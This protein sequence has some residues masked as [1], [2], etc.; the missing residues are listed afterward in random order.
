MRRSASDARLVDR[1]LD[2]DAGAWEVLVDRYARLVRSIPLRYGMDPADAD[3]VA[4]QTFVALF[5]ALSSLRETDRLSSW[6]VTTAH[7]AS[8]RVGGR[9]ERS[10]AAARAAIDDVGSPDPDLAERWDLAQRVREALQRLGGRCERLLT[11]LFGA[12]G[13]PD[14]RT[15][16]D[17]LEM[18]IGSIGPTRARCLAKLRPILAEVGIDQADLSGAPAEAASGV[19]DRTAGA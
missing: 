8:W 4:Q 13:D 12:S 19:A 18:P 14:Y 9:S 7:R 11:M 17:R 5:R 2:G 6:L 10:A 16:A 15:I 3:D 1:C